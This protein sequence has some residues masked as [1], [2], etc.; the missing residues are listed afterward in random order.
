M[1]V[2]RNSGSIKFIERK[3]SGAL[4]LN[5]NSSTSFQLPT[6]QKAKVSENQPPDLLTDVKRHKPGLFTESDNATASCDVE[7]E[8]GEDIDNSRKLLRLKCMRKSGTITTVKEQEETCLSSASD[9]PIEEALVVEKAQ[10]PAQHPREKA[11]ANSKEK[12]E[13]EKSVEKSS[14]DQEDTLY[15]AADYADASGEVLVMMQKAEAQH[16]NKKAVATLKGRKKSEKSVEKSSIEQEDTLYSVADYADA[17]GEVLVMMQ[18][19]EAQHKNKKAV[20]TLKGRK[21]SE[22]SVEKSSIE[23]EDTLYSVADYA[24]ASGEVLVM[25]QK[26]EAQHK[27]KKAVEK[28]KERKESEKSVEKSSIE[29]EDTLYSAADYADASGEVLVMMQKAE[30]QHKNKKAVEKLKERKE[31]EKSVEKSSIEQE[32]TLYSVADYAD[33]SGEVLVMMQKAEAQHKNKKAVEKLKERKESEKSVEKSSIEQED[34]LYS[35][36]DYADASGEV[37]VMMQKAEAQHKNK[38]AVEKL[39]ERKESEK[40][41]EKSSIEQEDTLY[42][43]ADYADASGEVLVMMQKAEVQ[44]QN[45][46]AVATLKERKESEKSVEKSSIEQE[47]TLYSVADY[48]DA[49]GEVL[50]MMQ[51]A[52]AQHKNKKAVEKL[53]ERKESEKSVEKSSIEQEDTLY[54]VAD[55]ADA[56]G[57]VLVMMQKA[58]AQHKNKKA[59]EKL[60][61]RKESEKSVEKSSIEQEDTLYSAADYADA[62]GEVLVMMQKAEAQHKNKKAVATLKGR[63][64]SEKSSIEQEDT[65][66]SA[67][68]YADASGEVLVMMQKAEVQHQRK[69]AVLNLKKVQESQKVS[70]KD[71]TTGQQNTVDISSVNDNN[72]VSEK[73]QKADS[74]EERL[75]ARDVVKE[76]EITR[77]EHVK[78]TS[79]Q[80]Q[81]QVTHDYVDS[82]DEIFSSPGLSR[83]IGTNSLRDLKV[84]SN[85]SE[86]SQGSHDTE[87][88]PLE[89]KMCNFSNDEP[90]TKTVQIIVEPTNRASES[91]LERDLISSLPEEDQ[92]SQVAR[93][94]TASA[95]V[96]TVHFQTPPIESSYQEPEYSLCYLSSS[97]YSYETDSDFEDQDP[98][99]PNNSK[100]QGFDIRYFYQVAKKTLKY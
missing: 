27:N 84:S 34:T 64:K 94:N 52:E 54:S 2:R 36:A 51:K 20:A 88:S 40:S 29:Q 19:A 55:Y 46:K 42:S 35:V 39:K 70:E 8:H 37:L 9:E 49:S 81:L 11:V 21:K 16:K 45:K 72:V 5:E 26:A 60:K 18:K 95:E 69:K 97:D 43:V 15:S 10:H 24:D 89:Q 91:H 22:K 17:S 71:T 74:Q 78:P 67:A 7:L 65:L 63:K 25:M 53:K 93:I 50:V 13:S 87:F 100:L 12:K 4:L 77:T 68:D 48:A 86:S 41:V 66:Y 38:K 6:V 62:S 61:E 57:E 96:A 75:T 85:E 47:D 82:P 3:G 1:I 31:S 98:N 80:R 58:E 83:T 44:H 92:V 76:K 90:R 73:E 23:Q 59:V 32:D 33:A 28:L 30:A 56:S 99:N 14:I 79:L